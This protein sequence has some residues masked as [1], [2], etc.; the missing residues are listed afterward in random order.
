V[1]TDPICGMAVDERSAELK[2]VRDNRTYFFCSAHCLREFADP[3]AELG[4]I[5]RRLI[6]GWPIAAIVAALTYLQPFST[7]PYIA[8]PLAAVV[9]GYCAWPFLR[10]T[11]DAARNRNWSMDVLIGVGTTTAFA[12][13]VAALALPG[14]LPASY[15]FDASSLIVVLILTGNYLEHFTRERARHVLRRLAE[16]VPMR[17]RRITDGHEEEVPVT[18]VRPGDRLRVRPGDRFPVDGAIAAGSTTADESL[19]TGESLP[20]PKG[21][22]APV[23]AGSLNNEGLVELR[24]AAV[25]QDTLLAEVGRLVAEAETSRV[26]MQAFADRIASVFVPVVLGLALLSAAGWA[27][28]GA[29]VVVAVLVFVSVVITACPCAFGIAT[30]AAIVVGTGRAAES[31]ILFK[32]RDAL[33]RASSVDLVVTDK[34]GTLTLGNPTLTDVVPASG[35]TEGEL[36]RAAAAVEAGSTHPL[37]RAVVNACTDRGI[38]LPVAEGIRAEAGRGVSGQV[39]GARVDVLG[40]GEVEGDELD[41]EWWQEAGRTLERAGRGWSVVVRDGEVAGILGFADPVAP[42]VVDAVTALR[43]DG[44]DLVIA[45]GDNEA[46]T[47]AV[48]DALGIREAHAR[49]TPRGKLELVRKLQAEGRK[50]AF[51]GDG[52]NDA[53][54]LAAADLG[55]AVGAGTDV[56]REA[57]GVVLLR[58][59]FDGVALALRI[60]RRTVRK[61]R[62]NVTWALGY[63][64]V[65]LP[66]AMGALVPLVGLGVFSLTPITGAVAMGLS[67]T[68]VVL[69]SLSLRWVSLR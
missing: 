9:Q 15:Y 51:V 33:E 8:A 3:T 42:G 50:V 24:A 26:P 67:S 41:R 44:I 29:G 52:I 62:G 22:G 6:V 43:Q 69:N 61:V 68:S 28:A 48:A 63:N 39:G 45:S 65:L 34:T 2:L 31:G 58:S 57:G 40:P 53:P 46:A 37:A 27:L 32:G 11:L 49:V 30:P 23:L 21:V 4:R 25:G 14:R 54:V 5:R 17:V 55:I 1:A 13:S 19:V 47:R 18:D 35:V 56:A 66:I 12:Y 60:G 64:A 20:V 10:G 7:W 38:T 36:L 59:R 16:L